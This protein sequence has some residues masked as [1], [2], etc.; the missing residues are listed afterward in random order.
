MN[1]S[2]SSIVNKSLAIDEKVLRQLKEIGSVD[3][4]I[5]IPSYNNADTIGRVLKAAEL[6]LAK[7]FPRNKAIILVSEGGSVEDTRNAIDALKD[8][9]YIENEF[10]D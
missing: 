1:R 10:I 5:G 3:I 9:H 7:Y 4:V 2:N 8:K 6:G